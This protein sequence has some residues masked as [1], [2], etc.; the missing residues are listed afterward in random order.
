MTAGC[1]EPVSCTRR[2]T[3]NRWESRSAAWAGAPEAVPSTSTKRPSRSTSYRRLSPQRDVGR[4]P[5]GPRMAVPRTGR[6]G[7]ADAGQPPDD[8]PAHGREP[9]EHPDDLLLDHPADRGSPED[10]AV[11]AVRQLQH[12]RTDP[13]AFAGVG[14]EQP[15]RRPSLHGRGQLPAEVRRVLNAGVHALAAERRVHVCG[16]AGQ[17]DP[18]DPVVLRLTALT[19]ETGAPPLLAHA[20][21]GAGD[22]AEAVL[23]LVHRQRHGQRDLLAEAVP[24]DGPEPSVA[25]RH[26]DHRARTA[27]PGEH[28]LLRRLGEPDVGQHDVGLVLAAGELHP[29]QV[30]DRAVCAVRT[31]QV[32]RRPAAPV[33]QIHGAHG[34]RPAAGRRPRR[35]R[36]SPRRVRGRGR[37]AP[38]RYRS[39]ARSGS[40]GTA[41][42][43]CPGRRSRRAPAGSPGP[44]RREPRGR[45]P[46]PARPGFRGYGR[47]PRTPG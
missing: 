4:P 40:S 29:D 39:A 27:R 3:F 10:Q 46:A 32:A 14:V 36:R 1:R 44:G 12:L 24:G 25:E 16:V 47:A 22:P 5:A 33:G 6:I 30:A 13:M 18:T 43:A 28:G 11:E 38:S 31:D 21:V 19:E 26:H 23:H 45:R 42:R 2:T 37:R 41:C 8:A 17:E 9:N 7:D 34:R 35:P 20:E 15:G